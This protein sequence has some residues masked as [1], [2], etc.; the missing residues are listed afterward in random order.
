MEELYTWIA[1]NMN[2]GVITL[3]MAIESSF[4]PFPSEIII[5]PA[6]YIAFN[7][8]TLSIPM[9]VLFGT[10]G[11]I[12]GALVNYGLSVWL[13]R[14]IIYKFADTKTAHML[15]IDRPG[16]EKAE[17]YFKEHGA[18]GTLI[19][20]LIPAIRQLISIPAGLARMKMSTFLLCTALGAG[21]WNTI[22]ALIGYYI[23]QTMPEDVLIAKVQEYSKYV[24][25]GIAVV[26]ILGFAYYI[27][28]VVKANKETSSYNNRMKQ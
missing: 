12:I 6:A 5:I 9:I 8:A 1:E 19:G 27:Y 16:V 11:A 18:I 20:R 10:I 22:L 21:L 25:E 23:G 14:P 26:L 2:Y 7:Q 17:E 28:K 13:G 4:I 3:F 24:K 15:L